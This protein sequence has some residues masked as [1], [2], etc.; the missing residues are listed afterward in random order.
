MNGDERVSSQRLTCHP[1]G[2]RDEDRE[3]AEDQ[4]G[5]RRSLVD[6]HDDLARALRLLPGEVART[7]VN[8]IRRRRDR[9]VLVD[10]EAVSASAA[11][12]ARTSAAQ[13]DLP[14]DPA[15]P[16]G[17]IALCTCQNHS[18]VGRVSPAA[19]SSRHVAV[20]FATHGCPRRG[21][22][23][24]C[25][26]LCAFSAHA[27]AAFSPALTR[28]RARRATASTPSSRRPRGRECARAPA[29]APSTGPRG[30]ES[31]RRYRC[32]APR[33]GPF[34]RRRALRR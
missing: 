22:P 9:D 14:I 2:A 24:T 1:E 15:P 31:R 5:D 11:G 12:R 7:R 13:L 16:D 28:D 20:T 17:M 6:D 23:E 27:D 21:R 25:Q 30:R 10:P 18:T 19:D 4:A 32:D 26:A 34:A 33:V 8:R 29:R 3:N